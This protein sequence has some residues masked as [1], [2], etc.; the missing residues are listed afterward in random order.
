MP[1]LQAASIMAYEERVLMRKVSLS[2]MRFGW[3]MPL[4]KFSQVVTSDS[5]LLRLFP[6]TV[7]CVVSVWDS[8]L[9][10]CKMDNYIRRPQRLCKRLADLEM[11]TQRIKRLRAIGQI[12]LQSVH[13]WVIKRRLVD[14]EDLMAVAQ[15]LLNHTAAHHA[16]AAGDHYA[17]FGTVR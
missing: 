14:V 10:T 15:Q 3:G 5:W 12:C 1:S 8:S 16:R 11:A 4:R 13:I 9:R 7:V 17:L 6:W 2:G